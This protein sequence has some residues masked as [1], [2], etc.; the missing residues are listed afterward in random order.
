MWGNGFNIQGWG[1]FLGLPV[2][3][4]IV[5]LVIWAVRAFGSRASREGSAGAAGIL[6]IQAPESVARQA[7]DERFAKGEL[8]TEQYQ[9]RLNVLGETK[10]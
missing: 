3:L 8:T 5:F 2:A 4:G 7:L 10:P 6:P 1:G 9:E